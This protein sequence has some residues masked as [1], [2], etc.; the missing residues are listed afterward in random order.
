[1][2]EKLLTDEEMKITLKGIKQRKFHV[3]GLYAYDENDVVL[4]AHYFEECNKKKLR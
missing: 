4:I 2:L 1:M 3:W